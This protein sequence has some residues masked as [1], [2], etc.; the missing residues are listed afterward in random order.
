[1]ATLSPRLQEIVDNLP[2]R[3]GLRV[4]EIGCGTGAAAREVARRVGP[5]GHVLAVD[6]SAKA[7]AAVRRSAAA[8]IAANR[9]TA[10]ELAAEELELGPGEARYDIA[11][12]VRVGAFDGRQPHAGAVALERLGHALLPGGRLFIDGGDPLRELV[13]TTR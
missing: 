13:V 7:I 11:F 4:I 12:A 8:L 3:P 10:R 2:L 6:R 9:L 5:T 1:M